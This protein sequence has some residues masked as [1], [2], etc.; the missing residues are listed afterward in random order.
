[1]IFSAATLSALVHGEFPSAGRSRDRKSKH[2]HTRSEAILD[3]DVPGQ[4]WRFGL[5]CLG[6]LLDAIA[7]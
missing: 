2:F 7:A 4:S 1:M 6:F 5:T 3:D